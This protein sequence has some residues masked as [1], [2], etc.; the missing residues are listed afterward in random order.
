MLST[1]LSRE[2]W[3]PKEAEASRRQLELLE[4]A[5]DSYEAVLAQEMGAMREAFE[6]QLAARDAQLA[7]LRTEHR[8]EL[9]ELH[10]AHEEQL[11]VAEAHGRHAR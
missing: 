10:A 1:I 7:T 4:S 5:D 3:D 9:R 2:F 8:R 6:A 11:R